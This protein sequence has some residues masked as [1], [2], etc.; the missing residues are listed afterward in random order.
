MNSDNKPAAGDIFRQEHGVDNNVPLSDEEH[1]SFLHN[2]YLQFNNDRSSAYFAFEALSAACEPNF[3]NI[4]PNDEDFVSVPWWA[5]RAIMIG[6]QAYTQDEGDVAK[7]WGLKR[8][9]GKLPVDSEIGNQRR[10]RSI[11]LDI[12]TL[13]NDGHKI[14]FAQK[15]VCEK[16]HMHIDAVRVVWKK[17]GS[18]DKAKYMQLIRDK[19]DQST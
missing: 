4:E 12:L 13:M 17:F 6:W 7:A 15:A 9:K 14:A 16:Y 1:R 2:L 11:F 10:N 5:A 19:S 3:R 18:E 8:S